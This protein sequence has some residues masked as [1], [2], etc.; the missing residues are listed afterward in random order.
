M[1]AVKVQSTALRSE[2]LQTTSQKNLPPKSFC[3]QNVVIGILY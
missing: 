3:A 2:V 1:F